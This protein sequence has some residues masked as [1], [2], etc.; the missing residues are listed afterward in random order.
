MRKWYTYIFNFDS[1]MIISIFLVV[2]Y[3]LYTR[4]DKVSWKSG[5]ILLPR[6]PLKDEFDEAFPTPKPKVKAKKINKREER[7]REIFQ[8][9]FQKQFK[10]IRPKWL[11]NPATGRN[12]ELDGF[13]PDIRTPLGM[14]LAFEHDGEQHSRY[15]P[16]FHKSGAKEFI[17]QDRKDAYKDKVCKEKG[18]L[19]IRVP[20]YVVFED[21]ER[22]IRDQLRFKGVNIPFQSRANLYG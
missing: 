21:L 7:C 2:V 1:I 22:Y 17:Y 5:E 14:G 3:L 16:H 15:V 6:I 19:L 9:I 13:C 8:S 18:V 10:S 20:H 4:R 12:L 11:E